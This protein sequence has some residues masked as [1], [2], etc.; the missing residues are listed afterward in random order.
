V[1]KPT[2][3]LPKVSQYTVA[4]RRDVQQVARVV[5]DASSRQEAIDIAEA[6]VDEDRQLWKIEE[7]IGTHKPEVHV[8]AQP[9]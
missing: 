5:V 6:W 1:K 4:L 8:K 3:K 7:H 9:K 2:K